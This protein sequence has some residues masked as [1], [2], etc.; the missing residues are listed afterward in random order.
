M[1]I[2]TKSNFA[3]LKHFTCLQQGLISLRTTRYPVCGMMH[4]ANKHFIDILYKLKLVKHFFIQLVQYL[5]FFVNLYC[6]WIF[7]CWFESRH[8]PITNFVKFIIYYLKGLHESAVLITFL[9]RI[10][11]CSRKFW[12]Y[13]LYSLK[14]SWC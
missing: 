5:W 7:I 6:K 8:H 12:N 2:I 4:F 1:L 14:N 11:L 9:C 10:W 13:I 3:L